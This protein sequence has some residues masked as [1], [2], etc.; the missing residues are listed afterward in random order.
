MFALLLACAPAEDEFVAPAPPENGIQLHVPPVELQPG[1]ERERCL[2][3]PT[4]LAADAWV[5]R[6]SMVAR[7]GLHHAMLVKAPEERT[8]EEECFGLPEALMEDYLNV[9]EPVFASSTQVTEDS[10]TFPD[11]VALPLA[12]G[13]PMM[14]NYHLLDTTDAPLTG[15]L[16]FNLEFLEEG[17]TPEAAR[18]YVMANITAID[19]PAQG[20]QTLT[21]TCTFPADANVLSLTPHMHAHGRSFEADLVRGGDVTP[22]LSTTGWSNPE[23]TWFDPGLT[24]SAGDGVRFT[25]AYTNDG[26]TAITFGPTADDEMCML[27][28]YHWPAEDLVWRADYDAS[29]CTL[30]AR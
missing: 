9:P 18:L 16:W 5:S 27:F 3:L 1:E 29:A 23:T 24:V 17:A 26:D 19:V 22:L 6:I 11:G 20:E 2:Y 4:T 8:D 15:E 14:V 12:A 7:D 13:Q 28:G 30:D 10:V 25:C 21:T